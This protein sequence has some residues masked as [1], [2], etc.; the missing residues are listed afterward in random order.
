MW[1]YEEK[2][3]EEGGTGRGD[4]PLEKARREGRWKQTFLSHYLVLSTRSVFS[5][6]IQKNSVR[7]E[8]YP[9]LQRRK[10][11]LR[12]NPFLRTHSGWS[13]PNRPP[14]PPPKANWFRSRA[15]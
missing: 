7:R 3:K 12:Q 5:F 6:S 14:P 8:S 4:I 2:M 13:D 11:G 15:A 1:F 9:I 10:Q